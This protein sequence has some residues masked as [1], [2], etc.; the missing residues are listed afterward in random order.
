MANV[1]T[2][3]TIFNSQRRNVPVTRIFLCTFDNCG[4]S[5]STVAAYLT[6]L[7]EKHQCNQC[8][9]E[10]SEPD[11]LI[12]K[13]Q[14]TQQVGG[15][16]NSSDDAIIPSNLQTGQFGPPAIHNNGGV[17]LF[18]YTYSHHNFENI[19]TFMDPYELLKPDLVLIIT[20]YVDLLRGVKINLTFDATL[21]RITDFRIQERKFYTPFYTI[22]SVTQIND[23]LAFG[24]SYLN[25][26]L[27]L[28]GE[29]Y[30][31]SWRIKQL[32][33]LILKI[34]PY[35]PRHTRSVPE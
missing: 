21:E 17:S 18:T 16:I 3:Q 8:G 4:E 9:T 35:Q 2:I 30:G 10:F 33:S 19:S 14:W 24:I 22:T 11:L 7:Y 5:F 23:R 12:H 26:S 15:G 27:E 29:A 34:V 13:R 25:L 6:H 32:N 31:S 1:P 20:Q 28:I